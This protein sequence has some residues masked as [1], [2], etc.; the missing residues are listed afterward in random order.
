MSFTLIFF[1][2]AIPAVLFA[3]V[4]K[5]GFAGGG[6]F[7]AAPILALVI[8]P[9]EAVGLMLPLLM[10][11]DVATL[12]PY[13]GKWDRTAA[14]LLLIGAL[15][16]IA[17]GAAVY[18]FTNPEVFKLLIGVVALG[19]VAFQLARRTGLLRLEAQ[20]VGPRAGLASGLVAGFTSFVANAGG[21]PAS[22][23]LLLKG[24]TK[25]E[26]QATSVIVFWAINLIKFIPFLSLGIATR[27]TLLADLLLAPVAL[28][29]AWL[30]IRAHRVVPERVFFGL[31]YVLLSLTGAKLIW[32]A[33]A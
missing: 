1:A 5:G 12:R 15:P 29:G 8:P 10:M 21:P 30:G 11:M 3:G 31:T 24:V 32:D 28:L 14:R 7:A 18:G 6:A 23:Y 22:V 20:G 17:L 27:Q 25:T 4:S 13:W 9:G 33:L 26:Y 2:V 19:F 16:G